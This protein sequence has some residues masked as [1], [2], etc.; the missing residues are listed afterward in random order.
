[1]NILRQGKKSEGS[2]E[3]VSEVVE[4]APPESEGG[5]GRG[6][7]VDGVVEYG[8]FEVEGGEGR[9]EVV[10][11]PTIEHGE[12]EGGEGA[13]EVVDVPLEFVTCNFMNK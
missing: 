5:E 13:W 7:V 1:V 11:V 9:W 3:V 4:L 10:Y 6:E 8:P 12:L 2:G